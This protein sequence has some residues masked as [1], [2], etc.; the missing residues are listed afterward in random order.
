MLKIGIILASVRNGRRGGQ[1][2]QWVAQAG[3]RRTDA[4]FVLIDLLDFSFRSWRRS[5]R[6]C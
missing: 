6:P 1:V 3:A 5:S 4:E 2:A